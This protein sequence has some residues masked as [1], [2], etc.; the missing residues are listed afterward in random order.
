MKHTNK[1]DIGYG[2]KAKAFTDMK[3][4]D[5]HLHDN[6]TELFLNDYFKDSPE[7]GSSDPLYDVMDYEDI[8]DSEYYLD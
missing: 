2:T 8:E 4:C 5:N 3:S 7:S 1:H 6:L